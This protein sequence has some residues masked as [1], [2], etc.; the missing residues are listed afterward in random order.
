MLPMPIVKMHYQES[1]NG[2]EIGNM[3][4]KMDHMQWWF[5]GSTAR[6]TAELKSAS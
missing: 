2:E 6:P 1:T 4:S 3:Y 5:S